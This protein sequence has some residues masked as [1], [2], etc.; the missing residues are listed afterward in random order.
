MTTPYDQLDAWIDAHFDEQLRFLQELIRVPT[1]T[2][3]GN[4]A[5]HAERTSA[6]LRGLGIEAEHYPVPQEEVRACCME[7][8]TN[9]L[10]RDSADA[11]VPLAPVGRP[12]ILMVNSKTCGFCRMALKDIAGLQGDRDS[13]PG[14]RVVTLEGEVAGRAML[15]QYGV[16]GAFSAGPVGESDQVLLTFRIP[17]TPVFAR[18]DSAGRI[19]ETVPGYPGPEVIA[20]WMPVLRWRQRRSWRRRWH[21]CG[22]KVS[23][24]MTATSICIASRCAN[25]AR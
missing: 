18:T 20:R 3:P 12:A 8:V 16:R 13:V 6:L 1:D 24:R 5:P 17:G 23:L 25:Q 9:L 15:R 7:S 2:P 19:V 14:L 11:R 10:V 21:R 22:S 4:N